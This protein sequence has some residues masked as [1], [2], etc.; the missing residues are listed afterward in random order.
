MQYILPIKK[1]LFT[2]EIRKI[3]SKH[4]AVFKKTSLQNLK[5]E[6]ILAFSSN[7]CGKNKSRLF[8]AARLKSKVFL[9]CPRDFTQS[10]SRTK[11]LD[12]NIHK[13][14][15]FFIFTMLQVKAN[16]EQ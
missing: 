2:C 14:K 11:T 15:L 13:T 8:R 5:K 4:N 1:N 16:G 12:K 3:F 9:K 6:E 7:L 10:G